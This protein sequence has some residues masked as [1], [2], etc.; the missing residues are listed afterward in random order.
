[1]IKKVSVIQYR[2]LKDL[3]FDFTERLNILSGTNGT[4]KTSLLHIVSNSFQA[5]TKTCDWIQDT[6]CLEIIKKVNSITNPKI[7]SLTKG[8]K[9]HNDPTNGQ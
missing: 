8:D 6:A 2:K 5:V 3:E 1:M 7:E 9:Q 4:C